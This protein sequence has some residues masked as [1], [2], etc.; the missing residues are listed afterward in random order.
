MH[1]R[2]YLSHPADFNHPLN[3]RLIGKTPSKGKNF[4]SFV[5]KSH[6][7]MNECVICTHVLSIL[8][9]TY[10]VSLFSLSISTSRL[11]PNLCRQF[12]QI[13]SDHCFDGKLSARNGTPVDSFPSRG[14]SLTFFIFS[15][16]TN[17]ATFFLQE[18]S[19]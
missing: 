6:K 14:I 19:N 10:L 4:F 12:R 11:E 18:K 7:E 5:T 8:I 9:D 2:E 15:L 16:S 13:R 17:A 3:R 1:N